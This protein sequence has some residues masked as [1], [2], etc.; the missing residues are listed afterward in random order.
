TPSRTASPPGSACP[1]PGG[2]PPGRPGGG[3]GPPLV[4]AG[5]PA[6]FLNPEPLSEFVDLF[7]VGEAEEMLPEFLARAAAGS[8]RRA[9]L[10]ERAED[11][12]GAYR[13]DRF[14]PRYDAGGTL[15]AA[16]SAGPFAPRAVAPHPAPL[17]RR[18]AR[19]R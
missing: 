6:T 13:P 2:A 15:A 3:R 10:L 8:P 4:P 16:A 19:W 1:A 9:A 14:H 7:L 11:V 12:V 18:A 17:A 5:A